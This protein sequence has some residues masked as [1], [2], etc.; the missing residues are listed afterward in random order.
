M[1]IFH[2]K[3]TL[4]TTRD[5]DS[6][7]NEMYFQHN[8]YEVSPF[9]DVHSA[10]WSTFLGQGWAVCWNAT[11]A[12]KSNGIYLICKLIEMCL[13]VLVLVL[14]RIGAKAILNRL[15]PFPKNFADT[16]FQCT[17]ILPLSPYVV[18]VCL[19]RFVHLNSFRFGEYWNRVYAVSL[20]FLF[21][22]FSPPAHPFIQVW[23][24]L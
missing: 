5:Y 24:A 19:Y 10:K 17:P 13:L 16:N 20:V 4:D 2:R 8:L 14:V 15:I 21:L 12:S 18:C 22:S 3:H 11:T 6:N 9:A 7:R 1:V 23:L